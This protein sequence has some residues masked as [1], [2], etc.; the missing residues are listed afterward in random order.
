MSVFVKNGDFEKE[1][2]NY[3]GFIDVDPPYNDKPRIM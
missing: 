1:L 2:Q 3:R